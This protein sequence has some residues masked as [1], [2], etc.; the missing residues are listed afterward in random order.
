MVGGVFLPMQAHRHRHSRPKTVGEIGEFSAL[1]AAR[2]IVEP[3]SVPS[4]RAQGRHHQGFSVARPEPLWGKVKRAALEALGAPLAPGKP[5]SGG[6]CTI[7]ATQRPSAGY[8]GQGRTAGRADAPPP[9]KGR[10]PAPRLAVRAKR[11]PGH[12]ATEGRPHLGAD[13]LVLGAH[14]VEEILPPPHVQRRPVRMG[15]FLAGAA[16]SISTQLRFRKAAS[17]GRECSARRGTLCRVKLLVAQ[18]K[19]GGGGGWGRHP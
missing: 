8:Y 18:R 10:H 5:Q 15:R 3:P 19:G 4:G 16:V 14:V 2:P 7:C 12:P 11:N 13:D 1:L 9:G 17:W 6:R